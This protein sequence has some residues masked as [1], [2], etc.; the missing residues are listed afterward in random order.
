[1]KKS[2]LI[3]LVDDNPDDVALT[4]RAF[5]GSAFPTEL[6][7]AQDGEEALDYLFAAGPHSDRNLEVMPEVVLLDLNLP[8]INGIEVLRRL[9]ANPHTRRLPVVILTSST[10]RSDLLS[11]YD[12]GANSFIRKPVDFDE[13]LVTTQQIGLYWLRLNEAPPPVPREEVC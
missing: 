7:V 12:L 9:R 1:M 2:H 5:E 3:L 10:E 8:K 4:L 13:F 11:A 6:T